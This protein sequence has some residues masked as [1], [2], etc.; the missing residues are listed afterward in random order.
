VQG[1]SDLGA[2]PE[3]GTFALA[4]LPAGTNS[5]DVRAIGFQPRSVGVDLASGRTATASV[6]LDASST[7]TLGTVTVYGKRTRAAKNL[8]GFLSR[9]RNGFGRYTTAAD[10]EKMSAINFTDVLRRTPGMQVSPGRGYGNVVR[11]RGGCTPSVVLDGMPIQGGADDIDSFVRPSEVSG[12]EV[13]SGMGG[14]PV[15]Y[16]N[17]NGCGMVLVWTKR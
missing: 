5:L 14:A 13:Y 9:S 2:T 12:I 6:T 4:G 11:G 15:E 10:I 17:M 7:Q 1:T 16:G 3:D 8:D